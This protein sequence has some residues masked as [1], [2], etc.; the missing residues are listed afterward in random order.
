[1]KNQTNLIRSFILVM[2]VSICVISNCQDIKK[3]KKLIRET[4]KSESK[5]NFE[6]IGSLIETR[7]FVF[8]GDF[9]KKPHQSS[10]EGTSIIRLENSKVVIESSNITIPETN[11]TT[12]YEVKRWDLV[13]ND[14][15][16]T[17]TLRFYADA[18]ASGFE[19]YLR[20]NSDKTALAQLGG[21]FHHNE[22]IGRIRTN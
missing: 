3:D 10:E 13:K 15:N 12:S 20:I 17:Y 9:T 4:K 2:G 22:F 14:K 6:A 11:K 1:M 18:R 8:E 19:V 5:R 21:G 7:N 16:L